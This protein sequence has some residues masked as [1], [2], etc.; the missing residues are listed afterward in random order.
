M[1]PKALGGIDSGFATVAI[2]RAKQAVLDLLDR[3]PDDCTLEDVLHHV[4]VLD[5]LFQSELQADACDLISHDQ[6]Q[7]ELRRRWVLG[8]GRA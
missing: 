8:D 7:Q 3:L 1:S 2:M 6:V 5:R 4:Y